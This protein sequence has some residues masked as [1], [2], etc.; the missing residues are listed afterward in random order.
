M[1]Y[2]IIAV[3]NRKLFTRNCLNS[4]RKQTVKDFITIVIDDGS[5]DGTAE[6]IKNEF[7]EVTLLHGNDSLWWAGGTNIGV[8]YALKSGANYIMT[9]NDDTITNI[10]F[11]EKM[12]YWS[13]KKPKAILGAFALDTDTK[14]PVY[15]GHIINWLTASYKPLIDH[16]AIDQQVGLR[17]VTQL[18]G[19]GLL[20]PAEVFRKI[21]LFD[22][23]NFPGLLA[24]YDFT[25]RAI[26]AGYRAFCNY[27]AKLL[28]YPDE[29]GQEQLRKVKSLKNYFNH[30]FGITGGGNLK[31]FIIYTFKNCPKIYL[32][33]F[34]LIGLSKRALG[35]LFDWLREMVKR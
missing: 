7:P 1:T 18:P 16:L 27:D 13:K 22:E 17:E 32:I 5:T 8:K 19:R 30:L 6:M 29:S 10:D 34:L 23:K 28:I 11:I 2:I 4:L 35:Y 24:D 20:I 33:P 25:H 26:K 21:G 14:R 15:G 12:L 31:R 9:L 3:F